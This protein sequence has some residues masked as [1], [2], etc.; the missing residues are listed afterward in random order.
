MRSVPVVGT[1]LEL[2]VAEEVVLVARLLVLFVV[3]LAEVDDGVNWATVAGAL[4]VDD[5]R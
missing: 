5:R 3:V 1:L 2:G 4:A